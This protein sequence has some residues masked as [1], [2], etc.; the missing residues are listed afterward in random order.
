MRSPISSGV[1]SHAF[2]TDNTSGDLRFLPCTSSMRKI[3]LP[4]RARRCARRRRAGAQICRRSSCRRCRVPRRCR[5]CRMPR[6]RRGGTLRELAGARA[7]R[8]EQLVAPASRRARSRSARRAG[9][10]RRSRRHRH[11]A[12]PRWQQRARRRS[13]RCCA[14]QELADLGVKITVLQTPE[15]MSASRGLKK[16]RKLDPEGTYDFNHVYLE[17]GERMAARDRA[18]A[19]RGRTGGRRRRRARRTHRWRHRRQPCLAARQ[20]R[21]RCRLRW[22][23][24]A[25]RTRHGGG[26]AAGRILGQFSGRC[27]A[28]GAVRRRCVLRPSRGRRGRQRRRGL[29]LDGALTASP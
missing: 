20:R 12:T 14:P 17:S 21:P 11:H 9:G 16:L 15:G 26:L 18:G 23:A 29:R 24:R 3:L 28:S 4:V 25:E 10:A 13:S 6:A 7:L 1:V 5:H 27:A 19:G 8:V 2:M 22:R